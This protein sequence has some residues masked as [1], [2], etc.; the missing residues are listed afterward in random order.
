M[1]LQS[2]CQM[3]LQSS[4]GSAGAGA[5]S[6]GLPHVANGKGPPFL[7]TC[8]SPWGCSLTTWLPPEQVIQ[9]R[10]GQQTDRQAVWDWDVSHSSITVT[11]A[12]FYWPYRPIWKNAEGNSQRYALKKGYGLLGIFLGTDHHSAWYLGSIY[13]KGIAFACS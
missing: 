3:G 9:K 4:E 2:H 13:S 11:S 5:S 1:K 8:A 6:S 10:Q 7:S 12:L